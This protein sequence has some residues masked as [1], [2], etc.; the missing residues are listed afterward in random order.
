MNRVLVTGALGFLG[1]AVVRRLIDAGHTPIALSSRP[2]ARSSIPSVETVHVDLR[3]RAKLVEV[4]RSIMPDGVCHL[5]ALT[6]VRDS[7]ESP[8]DYFDVNVGGTSALLNATRGCNPIPV[9][10]ASTVAVYGRCEGQISENHPVLPINPYGVSKLA[11]E[12]LLGYH[13][14]TG[15]VGATVLRCFNLSG[16]VDSVGDSDLTCIIPKALAVAAGQVSHVDINGDGSTVREFI[17]V[18]DAASAIVMGLEASQ[19]GEV[20]IY[21]VGSGVKSTILDVIRTVEHVTRQPVPV[22]HHPPKVEPT[23]LTANST[24]IQRELGWKPKYTSLEMMIADAW[25]AITMRM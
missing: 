17:H 25:K 5:A 11:A 7:F 12:Q 23:T 14:K 21:N 4:F 9:A 13:A 16:A 24:S 18:A 10:Y 3:D 20:A 1:H 19:A 15:A 8:L 2:R 22:K 6:R